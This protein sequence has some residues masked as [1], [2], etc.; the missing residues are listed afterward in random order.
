MGGILGENGR[1]VKGDS[2]DRHGL[3]LY[4]MAS[5]VFNLITNWRGIMPGT[6]GQKLDSVKGKVL[7]ATENALAFRMG[8]VQL[9]NNALFVSFGF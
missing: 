5:S 1:G 4:Y 8:D 6:S 2:F 3:L 9:Q 7:K